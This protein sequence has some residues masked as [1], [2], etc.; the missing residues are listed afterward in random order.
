VSVQRPEFPWERTAR[1]PWEWMRDPR[2]SLK[3]KGLLSYLLSHAPGYTVSQGQMVRESTDGRD[4]VLTGLRELEAAG[5]LAPRPS[6]ADA[7]R[8]NRGQFVEHDY[9]LQDPAATNPT[10]RPAPSQ[11][12]NGHRAE[13]PTVADFPS[14]S[15]RDGESTRKEKKWEGEKEETPPA[16]AEGGAGQLALVPGDSA[17]GPTPDQRAQ[18]LAAEH[19]EGV[20]KVVPFLG[21][22]S[23]VKAAIAAG[24]GDDQIRAALGH[25]RRTNRTLTKNALGLLLA[26]NGGSA[27]TGA[28][29]GP[30]YRNPDPKL[31]PNAFTDAF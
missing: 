21:I 7:P 27:V 25:L 4:S 13:N 9:L 28:N 12:G 16:A 18:A 26:G 24:H 3:G 20:G 6:R 15:A 8:G 11:V 22:R 5:Y 19:Y 2:L 10:P 30:R 14:R 23:I 17:D 31:H 1:V 29:Y